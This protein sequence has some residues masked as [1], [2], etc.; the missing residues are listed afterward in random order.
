MEKQS[1]ERSRL[2]SGKAPPLDESQ[3]RALAHMQSGRNVFLTGMAGTGKS[4]LIRQYIGQAFSERTDLCATTGIA[5]LNLQSGLRAQCGRDIPAHTIHR[6]AGIGIGPRQGQSGEEF[7]AELCR[8]GTRSFLAA[9]RRVKNARTLIVDEISMLPGRTLDYLDFH[10][11][12]IRGND[13][14]FGGVQLIAV[15]DFLQLPP[16]SRTG[17]YDWAFRSR[18][19]AAAGFTNCSLTRIHRQSDATFI[20]ILNDFR[21]GRLRGESARILQKRIAKFP[22]DKIV[23]LMTHNVQVDRWNAVKL[24]DIEAREHVFEAELGGNESEAEFLLKNL[25]TPNVLRLKVGARVMVTAN[26]ASGD[27]LWAANGETGTVRGIDP[28]LPRVEVLLDSGRAV[29]VDPFT[30]KYDR[31]RADSGEFT[32]LPLRLAYAMTVHKS[33]G[34]TLDAAIADIRAARDPGQAYVAVSRVRSLDG[35]WL[36]DAIA[37]VFVSPEAINFHRRILKENEI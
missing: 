6:W 17:I 21:E 25:V 7:F 8:T 36:K 34:L 18:A 32:Q 27:R 15:G 9:L 33:Q 1:A 23:R 14:P 26:V 35:L 5:A 4:Y 10:F 24:S 16:V 30:W 2:A 31:S 12:K 19:W 20:S 3:E 22:S 13:A 37:G 28:A 29:Q 11:R